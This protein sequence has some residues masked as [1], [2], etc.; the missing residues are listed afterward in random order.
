MRVC[1]FMWMYRHVHACVSLNGLKY[2]YWHTK[3]LL[4]AR[5]KDLK[6]NEKHLN[7]FP[8]AVPKYPTEATK[9]VKGLF[10]VAHSSKLQFTMVEKSQQEPA[11]AGQMFLKSIRQETW[12][13]MLS[14]FLPLCTIQDLNPGNGTTHSGQ[15]FTLC[16]TS[17]NQDNPWQACSEAYVSNGSRAHW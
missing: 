10:T 2:I 14:S 15:V 6:H 7:Q 17:F 12:A 8:N 1:M 16:L 3:T 9:N 11:A 13:F 4:K 5:K